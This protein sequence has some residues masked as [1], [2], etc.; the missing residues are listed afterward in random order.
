[1]NTFRARLARFIT[2]SQTDS[3]GDAA[4]RAAAAYPP[5]QRRSVDAGR[6][7][8]T[9]V[10][11][12]LFLALRLS[13]NLS[14]ALFEGDDR[15]SD[16]GG[17]IRLGHG[18]EARRA[19]APTPSASCSPGSTAL[20]RRLSSFALLRP[21]GPHA[22]RA[23]PVGVRRPGVDELYALLAG[24]GH[25]APPV[26]RFVSPC[27]IPKPPP[28][29]P[30]ITI[31]LHSASPS[32]G[33]ARHRPI[34]LLLNHLSIIA[35]YVILLLWLSWRMTLVCLALALISV[36]GALQPASGAFLGC[37]LTVNGVAFNERVVEYSGSSPASPS[38][39]DLRHESSGDAGAE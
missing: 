34:S 5:A 21:G 30:A 1:M 36:A 19:S 7:R 33:F 15:R 31:Q 35:G 10:A 22:D 11:L 32:M 16:A 13:C 39:R 12:P 14:A 38:A 25:E 6:A 28:V 26:R 2:S 18:A 8:L 4:Q 29:A 9:A 27:A 23:Q 3:D 37:F 17:G 20:G 24:R